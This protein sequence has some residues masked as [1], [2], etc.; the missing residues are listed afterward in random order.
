M[1]VGDSAERSRA[2]RARDIELFTELTGDTN[3][4][5]Y[6]AELA[7]RSRFGAIVVRHDAAQPHRAF[8]VASAWH[9]RSS[10]S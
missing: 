3:P 8:S 9:Q 7:A 5:H 2:V 10:S 1:R 6:D 4:V